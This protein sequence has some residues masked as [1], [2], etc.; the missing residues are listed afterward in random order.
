MAI[1]EKYHAEIH[2]CVFQLVCNMV[3]EEHQTAILPSHATVIMRLL[4]IEVVMQARTTVRH[5]SCG[6]STNFN[7]HTMSEH[8]HMQF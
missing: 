3:L 8:A 2:E 1:W 7:R 5:R 4:V 6:E